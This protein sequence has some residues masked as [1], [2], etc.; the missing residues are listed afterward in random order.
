MNARKS[1]SKR[2]LPWK[3]PGAAARRRA[4]ML[5]TCPDCGYVQYPFQEICRRCLGGSPAPKEQPGGGILQA[6]TE[7]HASIDEFLRGY[8]PLRIGS[9]KLDCG[10]VVIAYLEESCT[11]RTRRVRVTAGVD[12]RGRPVLVASPEK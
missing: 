11:A 5:Q 4:L 8:L 9:I 3:R 12:R 1:P 7:L 10:P 6:A 2:A